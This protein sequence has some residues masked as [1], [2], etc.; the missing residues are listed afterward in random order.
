MATEILKS[1]KVTEVEMFLKTYAYSETSIPAKR[2]LSVLKDLVVQ[3]SINTSLI[4]IVDSSQL[5]CVKYGFGGASAGGFGVTING[6]EVLDIETGM[7]NALGSQKS[8]NFRKLSNFLYKLENDAAVRYLHGTE[9]FMVI[10]NTTA[11]ADYHNGT[12]FSQE[13]FKSFTRLSKLELY[14]GPKLHFIHGEVTHMIE[15]GTDGLS[16]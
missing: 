1:E 7:C 3:M 6:E 15:Q 13:W 16:R 4:L 12:S 2:L 5:Q 14:R 10:E 9:T 8:Y 11:E